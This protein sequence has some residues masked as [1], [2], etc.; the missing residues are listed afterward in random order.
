MKLLF[1]TGLHEWNPKM[2]TEYIPLL[3]TY[4]SH[5]EGTGDI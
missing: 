2:T 1:P 5:L 4:V 3:A